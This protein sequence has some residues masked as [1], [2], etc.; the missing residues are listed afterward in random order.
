LSALNAEYPQKWLNKE[1][2][3]LV[4][5]GRATRFEELADVP[6]AR[7]LAPDPEA[8]TLIE[9]AECRFSSRSLLS[10]RR[11]YLP[12]APPRCRQRSPA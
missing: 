6:T 10:R 5:L 4:Q 11:V 2:R 1:V 8:R 7:E 3:P 12:R 9:F